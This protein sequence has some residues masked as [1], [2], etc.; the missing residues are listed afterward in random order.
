MFEALIIACQLG[1]PG[2]CIRVDD[3]R[4]PY[5]THIHCEQRLTEMTQDLMQIWTKYEMPFVFRGH[6]C[7][8]LTE[9]EP[10]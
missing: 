10:A 6:H 1:A 4:G 8:I 9:G 2:S 5:P 7:T 3:T